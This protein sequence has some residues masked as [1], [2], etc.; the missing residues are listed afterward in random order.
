MI[1][2]RNKWFVF[3]HLC[4]VLYIVLN[5]AWDLFGFFSLTGS[6]QQAF[7]KQ[8]LSSGLRGW[9]PSVRVRAFSMISIS[10]NKAMVYFAHF[11]GLPKLSTFIQFIYLFVFNLFSVWSTNWS[12]A[13]SNDLTGCPPQLQAWWAY[14]KWHQRYIYLVIELRFSLQWNNFV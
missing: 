10:L 12:Q 1:I 5:C 6:Y 8:N 3:Q 9:S 11:Q 7:W 2:G 4:I 13:S 14:F